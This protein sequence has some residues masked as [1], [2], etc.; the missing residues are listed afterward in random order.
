MISR[1]NALIDITFIFQ[2]LSGST[3][4]GFT[5]LQRPPPP[6]R[7]VQECTPNSDTSRGLSSGAREESEAGWLTSGKPGDTRRLGV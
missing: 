4:D 7:G 1:E 6:F 2:L 5:M 3:I